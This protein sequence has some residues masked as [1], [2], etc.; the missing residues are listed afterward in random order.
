MAHLPPG[1]VTSSEDPECL[2]TLQEM[3]GKGSYGHVYKAVGIVGTYAGRTVAIKIISLDVKE[4]LDDVRAEIEILAECHHPNIVNYLGSYY[5]DGNLW[6]VMEYCGGGS[7]SQICRQMG[8]SLTEN[9]IALVCRETLK[10]LQYFHQQ[11][12]IH[13][14][15]KGGNILLTDSGEVKLADF[16]VS[17]KLMNTFS[18]RNT[19]AGT[20]YWM[21]PEI[22]ENNSTYN[23]KA[24]IWSLGITAIEMAETVPP[25]ADI[26]PMRVLFMIPNEPAPK[27]RDSHWSLVFVDFVSKCLVK[28]QKDR[29]SAEELLQHRFVTNCKNKAIL[30]DLVEKAKDMTS[31]DSHSILEG[32]YLEKTDSDLDCGTF[33]A[34]SGDEEDEFGTM[35]FKDD[36]RSQLSSF[37]YGSEDDEEVGSMIIRRGQSQS[38][39]FKSYASN[40]RV[41]MTS[42]PSRGFGLQDSLQAIYR[43]DCCIN[44]PFLNLNYVNA[45][46]LVNPDASYEASRAIQELCPEQLKGK[47]QYRTLQKMDPTLSNLLRAFSYHKDRQDN[48]PASMQDVEQNNRIVSELTSVVKTIL[49][50]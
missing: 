49:K 27:L 41:P 16:G 7:I 30:E 2:F 21:A 11:K 26:H 36:E 14:D 15:I 46:F 13:R 17:A 8:T 12:K 18:K 45:N 33:V 34:C 31:A 23:S 9:Q 22:I 19:F 5:K 6:I 25:Y 1:L 10:G 50:V 38:D 20:P 40:E 28:N 42:D 4:A 3:L 43:R 24:D 32:T 37:F 35:V 47:T 29:P 44:I 39:S 48:I